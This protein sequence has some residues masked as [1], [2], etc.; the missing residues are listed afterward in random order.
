MLKLEKFDGIKTYMFPNGAVATPEEIRKQFPAVDNF[1]HVLEVNGDVCQAV[2]N[3]KALRNIHKIDS[4]LTEAEAIAAI[5]TK[6]NTP[7][8]EIISPEERLAAAAEFQ[9]IL[10]LPDTAQVSEMD[11]T[12]I[13]KNVEAGL[14]G[15]AHL[16]IV[17]QKG[18]IT[19]ANANKIITDAGNKKLMQ[20]E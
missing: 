15:T 19:Q 17:V 7:P 2:M 16:G 11:D 6:V 10:A 3:L 14:W 18:L 8:E 13:I 9:N 1:V 12:I 5:E 20:A 4:G